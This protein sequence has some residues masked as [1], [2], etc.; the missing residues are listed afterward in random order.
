VPSAIIIGRLPVKF[1]NLISVRLARASK[2]IGQQA[3]K[4]IQENPGPGL[5]DHIP[6]PYEGNP[7]N[8]FKK[9][10]NESSY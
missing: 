3:I 7:E 10:K 4:D 5:E 1:L 8:I 6:L 2:Y 9:E